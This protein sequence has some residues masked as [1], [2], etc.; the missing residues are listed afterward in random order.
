MVEMHLG[1][2]LDVITGVVFS[3]LS[4]A[5]RDLTELRPTSELRYCRFTTS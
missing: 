5:T 3:K 2:T 4:V 1:L